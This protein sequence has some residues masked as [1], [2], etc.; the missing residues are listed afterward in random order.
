M[1]ESHEIKPRVMTCQQQAIVKENK[2]IRFILIPLLIVS[3]IGGIALIFLF[4]STMNILEMITV[5]SI[6][7]TF[8]IFLIVKLIESRKRVVFISQ[9]EEGNALTSLE[10]YTVAVCIRCRSNWSKRYSFCP[11]CGSCRVIKLK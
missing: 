5:S 4:K 3:V 7:A 11:R 9:K 8:G 10:D 2:R 1:I 6:F